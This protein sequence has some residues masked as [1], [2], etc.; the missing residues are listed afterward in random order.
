[1]RKVTIKEVAE[2]S[3]VSI[4]TVSRVFNNNT[5]VDPV[6]AEKVLKVSE[7]L[8]YQPSIAARSIRKGLSNQIAFIVP[9]IENTYFSTIA[10]GIINTARDNGQNVIVMLSNSDKERELSCFKSISRSFIDGIIFASSNGTNPIERFPAL[11]DT[12]MVVAARRCLTPG[13]SHVY[14]D[15]EAAGY[16]ATKYL[17]RLNHKRVAFF[18]NF[19]GNLVNSYQDFEALYHSPA[20]NAFTA[21]D[22]YTGYRRA[23]K[24]EGID[25]DPQ[26]I[27]YSGYTY[28]DG[29]ADAQKLLAS[30]VEFDSILTPNDRSGAGVLRLLSEQGFEVPRQVSV[31]GFNGG[32]L[33]DIANPALTYIQ[34]DNYQLGLLAAEQ[35][36]AVIN[37][38][39]AKDI[40]IDVTL[41]I[42]NSTASRKDAERLSP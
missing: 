1:L 12:P 40:K 15:N 34:Q 29:Y 3:G 14:S 26:L 36:N 9:S 20:Q 30:N 18:A 28:E 25:F 6:L 39:P 23:L 16:T 11:K 10:S 2:L 32:Q 13:I 37:G 17:L 31:I 27:F 41:K 35:L 33:S 42:Q 7:H 21:F 5:S 38:S 4:S 19:W 22:R 24:E 8:N